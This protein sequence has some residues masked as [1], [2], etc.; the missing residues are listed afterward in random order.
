L[1]IEHIELIRFD[2]GLWCLP[3][4]S[5]ISV[6]SWRSVLLL[7]ET[8]VPEK[9]TNLSQV[10]DKIYYIMLYQVHLAWMGFKLKTLVV[11][12]TDCIGSYKSNYQTI[13]TTTAHKEILLNVPVY[14]TTRLIGLRVCNITFFSTHNFLNLNHTAII[15]FTHCLLFLIEKLFTYRMQFICIFCQ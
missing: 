5:N 15:I 4:F 6:I 12:G 11:I 8:R 9:T 2:L 10:T 1:Q 13:M 14:M 3:T 7:E